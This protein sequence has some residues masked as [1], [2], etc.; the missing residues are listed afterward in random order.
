[1]VQ[2][3]KFDAKTPVTN[4]IMSFSDSFFPDFYILFWFGNSASISNSGIPIFDFNFESH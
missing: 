4:K 2:N 3:F 1:M